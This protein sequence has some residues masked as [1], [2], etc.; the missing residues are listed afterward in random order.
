MRVEQFDDPVG[1]AGE[2]VVAAVIKTNRQHRSLVDG[3]FSNT[4][5]GNVHLRRM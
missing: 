2:A 4:R 1:A 3:H 5:I